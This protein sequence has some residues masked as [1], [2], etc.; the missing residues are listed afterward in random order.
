MLHPLVLQLGGNAIFAHTHRPQSFHSGATDRR[1][2]RQHAMQLLH[3][4]GAIMSSS[5]FTPGKTSRRAT[6]NSVLDTSQLLMI[7]MKVSW[8]HPEKIG[9]M[10]M[11]VWPK[12]IGFSRT[13]PLWNFWLDVETLLCAKG[14]A[15]SCLLALKF[16]MATKCNWLLWRSTTYSVQNCCFLQE[17][18]LIPIPK[19]RINAFNSSNDPF[20]KTMKYH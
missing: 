16:F 10:G 20:F 7:E 3:S 19:N 2:L 15:L 13:K 18:V 6:A 14:C 9:W 17:T 4:Q 8:Q 12:S 1:K 11:A 5:I